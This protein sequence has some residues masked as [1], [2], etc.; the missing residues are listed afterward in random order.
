M[1][2]WAAPRLLLR[3]TGYIRAAAERFSVQIKMRTR[4]QIG[5]REEGGKHLIER[6]RGKR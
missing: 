1:Q 2:R 6:V 3:S 4:A 5:V